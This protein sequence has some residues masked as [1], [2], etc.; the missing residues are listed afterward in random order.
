MVEPTETEGREELD[1]F[2]A[3][4]KAID[5]EC[6]ENPELVRTAPHR[7]RVGRLDEVAAAR[8]LVL[9]WRPE[10]QSAR[11]QTSVEGG[12]GEPVASPES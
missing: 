11:S 4:M 2:I 8:H 5:R 12:A 10:D 7:T 3:A 9:R 1:L 6:R